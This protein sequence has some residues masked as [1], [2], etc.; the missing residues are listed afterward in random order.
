MRKKVQ[1]LGLEHANRLAALGDQ[2]AVLAGRLA[3]RLGS[4]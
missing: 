4:A 3:C 1:P 2:A